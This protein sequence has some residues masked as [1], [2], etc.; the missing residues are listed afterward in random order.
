MEAAWIA[1]ASA[2]LWLGAVGLLRGVVD[3]GRAARLSDT[4]IGLGLVGFAQASPAFAVMSMAALSG[5]AAL[6]AGALLTAAI[7]QLSVVLGV[8]ALVRP[9]QAERRA[10]LRGALT[11]GIVA[12]YAMWLCFSEARTM[13]GFG[14]VGA[15][16]IAAALLWALR[17]RR[18]GGTGHDHAWR[19]PILI[20]KA[21][22]TAFS[23]IAIY[24]LIGSASLYAGARLAL[25]I[26]GEIAGQGS[27]SAR[28]LAIGLLAFALSV[29]GAGA[30]L[31][32]ALS[33]RGLALGQSIAL[34]A[35]GILGGFCLLAVLGP[36]SLT[37]MAPLALALGVMILIA[38]GV[39]TYGA[40]LS[41]RDG[42][43]L[44]V[45]FL[46]FAVWLGARA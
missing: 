45:C 10:A 16:L 3:L 21:N 29:P 20:E 8:C 31:G 17:L 37:A 1:L 41:R 32:Q 35:Y 22:R 44:I 46:G 18:D 23:L 36:A 7:A 33:K 14:F 13:R 12:L 38:G 26:V 4:A 2:L 40:G 15:V 5:K 19:A 11:L 42:L 30:M 24:L 9:V 25:A 6:A 28:A 27:P 34:P 39:W 43:L